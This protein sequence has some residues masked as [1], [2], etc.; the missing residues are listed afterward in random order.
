MTY[1]AFPDIEVPQFLAAWDDSS[2]RN[3][4]YPKSELELGVEPGEVLRVW[5]APILVEDREYPDCPRFMVE[6]DPDTG[7]WNGATL[8]FNGESEELAVAVCSGFLAMRA[9][10]RR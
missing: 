6:Y 8:L 5:V 9:E 3:D 10:V 7:A 2:W 1:S 4:V